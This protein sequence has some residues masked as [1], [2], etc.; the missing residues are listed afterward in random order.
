MFVPVITTDAPLAF[1]EARLP[2]TL[3]NSRVLLR[4]FPSLGAMAR[5][6]VIHVRVFLR[7]QTRCQHLLGHC[8]V[9]RERLPWAQLPASSVTNPVKVTVYFATPVMRRMKRTCR[10]CGRAWK[11]LS[12]VESKHMHSLDAFFV[13]FHFVV[14]AM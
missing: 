6:T 8:P 1:A 3:L 5:L 10:P 9:T 12:S 7:F 4:R 2:T 14:C 11:S 13:R